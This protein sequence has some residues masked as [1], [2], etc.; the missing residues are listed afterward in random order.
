MVDGWRLV[1]PL[2]IDEEIPC[3]LRDEKMAAVTPAPA[4]ADTP[5]IMAIVALDM[6]GKGEI[7]TF[8]NELLRLGKKGKKGKREQVKDASSKCPFLTGI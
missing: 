2:G 3:S 5:A 6:A 7:G 8:R 4:A 1:V